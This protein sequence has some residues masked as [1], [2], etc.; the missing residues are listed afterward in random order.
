MTG[1]LRTSTKRS[2]T[3]ESDEVHKASAVT[4]FIVRSEKVAVAFN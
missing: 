1:V 2:S 3:D 4:S